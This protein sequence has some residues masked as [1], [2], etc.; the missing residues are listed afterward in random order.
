MNITSMGSKQK[1]LFWPLY[2]GLKA[3]VAHFSRSLA[4]V[5]GADGI[6]VNCVG[7]GLT[8]TESSWDALTDL[9]DYMVSQQPI[10]PMGE[11]KDIVAVQRIEVAPGCRIVS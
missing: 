10:Q 2:A 9:I 7:P 1:V 3:G 5:V 11:T 8:D 6:T 4:M